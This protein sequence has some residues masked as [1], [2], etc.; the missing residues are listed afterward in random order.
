MPYRRS[1]AKE[2]GR[3]TPGGKASG[4]HHASIDE[5]SY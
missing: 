5:A 1:R 4:L 2:N 3:I